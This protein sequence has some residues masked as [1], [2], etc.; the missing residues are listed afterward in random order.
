M[1]DRAQLRPSAAGVR[2]RYGETP[3]RVRAWVEDQLGSPVTQTFE[4][5]G[6]MSPGCATRLVT[7]DGRRGFVKAVSAELNP[8]TPTLFRSEIDVLRTLG[9][10]ELWADLVAAYDEA[11]PETGWVA[12]L[13]EDIEG[14]Q[15]DIADPVER[16]LVL[17]AVNQIALR[18]PELPDTLDVRTSVWA[19]ERQI[20]EWDERVARHTDALPG[21]L[22]A[23]LDRHRLSF[24]QLREAARG[25]G[26]VHN[27]VRDDNMI[28]RPDGSI[29]IID[30]GN[31]RRGPDWVDPL[32]VRLMWV[33]QPL[34]DDLVADC[35]ALRRFGE[36]LVTTFLLSFGGW[37]A[38]KA[39][40]PVLPGLPTLNAFRRQQGARMLEGARRRLGIAG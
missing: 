22:V 12:L 23:D 33:D 38:L 27:D 11:D 16:A 34:F 31:V 14:C 29:C 1:T 5:T 7:A 8:R 3:A 13:L 37:L 6:G 20:R 36:H 25:N 9:Y 4:Q 15:P 24:E 32:L 17:E 39:N 26:M 40:D 18:I 28:L 35:P 21:W 10:G 2:K 19:V 30:W